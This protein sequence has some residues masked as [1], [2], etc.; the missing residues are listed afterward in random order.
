MKI[1]K[2]IL[3]GIVT[4]VIFVLLAGLVL[5]K[6]YSVE[7]E[8]T[9]N[10]PKNVVFDYI[11]YLKNQN[12]YSKWANID[13]NMTKTYEGTDATVGFV[14]AW[15]SDNDDVGKGEQEIK[16]ITEGDRVDYEIRF[17]EPFE[18]KSS[19]YMITDSVASNKTKVKWGFNGH[20][21]YPTNLMLIFMDFNKMIG[22]DLDTGLKN[23]KSELEE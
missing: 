8:I 19:A 14:S 4:L 20:M 15:D 3:I 23:L 22:D 13:P 6:D 16:K 18:S 21:N 5:K 17:I 7:R 10:R 1:L 9:V 2:Y 11:K 12:N